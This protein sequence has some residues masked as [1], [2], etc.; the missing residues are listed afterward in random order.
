MLIDRFLEDAFEADVDATTLTIHGT[1]AGNVAAGERVELTPTATVTGTL[2]APAVILRDGATFNG[3]I[4]VDKKGTAA[5]R[6]AK[7]A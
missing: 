7:T 4:Q 5:K 2:V 3:S 6:P 1:F